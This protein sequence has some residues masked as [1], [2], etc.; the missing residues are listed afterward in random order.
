MREVGVVHALDTLFG[1]IGKDRRETEA[2][3]RSLN[4][5]IV[6]HCPLH[7]FRQIQAVLQLVSAL[8]YSR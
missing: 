2:K 8:W 1:R 7:R 5:V 6:H 3:Q 4:I